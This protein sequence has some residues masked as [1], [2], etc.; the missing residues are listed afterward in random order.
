MRLPLPMSEKELNE[1]FRV[2]EN[3]PLLRAVLHMLQRER[4]ISVE[5]AKRGDIKDA[6][7]ALHCGR[8]DACDDL[9]ENIMTAVDTSAA[10]ARGLDPSKM[11][12]QL[13]T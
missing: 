9:Q 5:Y 10:L 11:K 6:D 13:R 12:P 1:A 2:D 4:E 8:M 3:N 7:R